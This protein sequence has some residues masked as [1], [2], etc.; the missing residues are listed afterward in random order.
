MKAEERH[1]L[2]A[3][4]LEVLIY[5]T[6]PE[7][8]KRNASRLILVVVLLVLGFVLYRNW[9]GKPQRQADFAAQRLP[10]VRNVIAS[11]D[12][13]LL[14]QRR[15]MASPEQGMKAI[16][17]LELIIANADRNPLVRAECYT[18]LGEVYLKLG[19]YPDLSAIRSDSPR[20]NMSAEELLDRAQTAYKEVLSAYA[21]YPNF[22][23]IARAGLASVEENRARA[24]ARKHQYDSPAPPNPHLAAAREYILAN[25]QDTRQPEAVREAA[26]RRIRDLDEYMQRQ[27][28][29]EPTQPTTAPAAPLDLRLGSPPTTGPIAPDLL[30]PTLP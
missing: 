24:F 4:A 12:A 20:P 9:A 16:E 5:H 10:E 13:D 25:A 27:V 30:T 22:V 6:G 14:I 18:L 3:N 11:L 2:K 19:E 8:L 21:E 26:R 7:W 29:A 1:A 15:R 28:F 23:A 17:T